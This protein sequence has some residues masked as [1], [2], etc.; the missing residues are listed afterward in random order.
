MKRLLQGMFG[1]L[2]AVGLAAMADTSAPDQLVRERT[3]HII[4]LL[5]AHKAEYTSD[6][7]K[8]YAMV[9]E[10]VLPYFDFRVMSR[11]VL[12]RYWREANEAQ[13][14][15]FVQEFRDLLVRTYATA[16]LKYTNEEIN[17]L[18]FRATPGDKTAVVRTEV[19]QPSGP[20]IPIS[21][22]FY[23]SD[24]GWKVYDVSIEN[25]SLVTNYRSTYATTVRNQGLDALIASM[26]DA[27]RRGQVDVG[28]PG[29]TAGTR[30]P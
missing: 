7:K 16:L 8:L 29:S 28:A 24:S 17:Y 20:K 30:K 2:F 9:D 10:Q 11:S 18:P 15:K 6:H 23:Q 4:E 25:V 22:S 26:A 12:G 14:S 27:N 5:K 13:R 19:I 21:Y 3:T 1:L